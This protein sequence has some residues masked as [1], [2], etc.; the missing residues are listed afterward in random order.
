METG[1]DLQR[2]FQPYAEFLA[3]DFDKTELVEVRIVELGI[4]KNVAPI[5][6]AR[7]EMNQ[8]DL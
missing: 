3:R 8:R 6:Q 5:N 2:A 4:E 7:G 1:V